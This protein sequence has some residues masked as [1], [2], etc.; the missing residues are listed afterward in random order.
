V[1]VDAHQGGVRTA[2]QK[3]DASLKTRGVG[4]VRLSKVVALPDAIDDSRVVPTPK[5]LSN[6]DH[7]SEWV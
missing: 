7:G 4:K 6:V 2:G 3:L 5:H 1:E